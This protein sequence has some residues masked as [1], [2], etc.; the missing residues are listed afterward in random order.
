MLNY[1]KKALPGCIFAIAIIVCLLWIPAFLFPISGAEHI[2]DSYPMPLYGLVMNILGDNYTVNTLC[3]VMLMIANLILITYSDYEEFFINQKTFLPALFYVIINCAYPG[4]QVMNPV[5]VATLFLNCAFMRIMDSYKQSGVS[6]HFFDAALIIGI[7]S[8]FYANLIWYGL[9]I[10]IGIIVLRSFDIRE[11][12]S[13]IIGLV[14]PLGITIAIYYLTDQSIPSLFANYTA[15]LF[16]DD[17]LPFMSVSSIIV[18]VLI[19]VFIV[20][21]IFNLIGGMNTKKIKVRKSFN[22]LMWTLAI[23]VL[24]FVFSPSTSFEILWLLSFPCC[25]FLGH[26]FVYA[27]RQRLA[28]IMFDII[29][30][31]VC[32]IQIMRFF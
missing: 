20:I 19:G 18:F 16:M 30:L 10:F 11:F 5:I 14:T 9:L 32:A 29:I 22:M 4:N 23:S 7:G 17:G 21:S 8:L 31:S 1:F 3:A 12:L 24:L 26:Y 28:G 6:S 13:G 15:N 25:F 2:Y 27:K